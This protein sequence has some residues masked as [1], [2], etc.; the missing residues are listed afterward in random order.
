MSR[1]YRHK[2]YMSND[3]DQRQRP[4]GKRNDSYT[5][6][7]VETSYRRTIRCVECSATVNF[8]DELKITDTCKN[9]D[10]D[11]HTCR[12]CKFFDPGAPNECMKPV[13]QRIES[14][15]TRNVCELFQ[16]KVLVEKAVEA[17]KNQTADNARQA[18]EDLFR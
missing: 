6:G 5:R 8:I 16:P 10:A 17:K 3:D 14:K 13:T 15:N 7:R 18:F 1:K 11:L 9:C 4:R 12:N 2:G